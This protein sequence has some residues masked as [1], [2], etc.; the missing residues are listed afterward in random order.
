MIFSRVIFYVFY[1]WEGAC[2]HARACAHEHH[3]RKTGYGLANNM[4]LLAHNDFT[5]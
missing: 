5:S 3:E 2:E 4:A 1:V